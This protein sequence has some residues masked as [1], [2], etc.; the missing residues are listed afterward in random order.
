MGR[1]TH[2]T[3]GQQPAASLKETLITRNEH[4]CGK[5]LMISFCDLTLPIAQ[6]LDANAGAQDP[7]DVLKDVAKGYGRFGKHTK[8]HHAGL[9][10]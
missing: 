6:E 2:Q 4:P 10:C 1:P 9:V 8:S 5:E 3:C 7:S